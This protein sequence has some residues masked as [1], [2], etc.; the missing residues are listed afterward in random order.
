MLDDEA[1]EV[2]LEVPRVVRASCYP[3]SGGPRS[4]L[5]LSLWSVTAISFSHRWDPIPA[6]IKHIVAGL[7]GFPSRTSLDATAI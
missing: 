4:C 1:V 6:T 3:F 2:D 7:I 5:I